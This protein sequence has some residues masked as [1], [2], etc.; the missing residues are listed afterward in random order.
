MTLHLVRAGAEAAGAEA[1]VVADDDWLVYLD[2][3]R[4]ADHG[5]PTVP[6]GPI[7]HDQLVLLIFAAARVITW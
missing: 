6:P 4:L 3:Q 1:I 2:D 5:H 7:D